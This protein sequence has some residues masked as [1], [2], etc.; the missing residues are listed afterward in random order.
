MIEVYE[1]YR[2]YNDMMDLTESWSRNLFSSL[3]AVMKYRWE[4]TINLRSPWKRISME[5]ALKEYAGLGILPLY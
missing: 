2:D 1:A 5:D 4:K 3:Q